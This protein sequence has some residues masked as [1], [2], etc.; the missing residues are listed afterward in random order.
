VA[1]F[2][3]L[4]LSKLSEVSVEEVRF[5]IEIEDLPNDIQLQQDSALSISAKVKSSGFGFLPLSFGGYDPIVLNAE[6]DLRRL[7]DNQYLWN[8]GSGFENLQLKVSET[9]EIITTKSDS[10][11]FPYEVLSSKKLPIKLNSDIDFALGFDMLKPL[12]LS[13]DSVLVIGPLKA[14]DSITA[15]ETELIKLEAVKTSIDEAV[16]LI[17]P[18]DRS[19]NLNLDKISVRGTVERFTE[20]SIVIPIE[21]INVPE[22]SQINFFPKDITLNYYVSLDNYNNISA[23]DFEVICDFQETK[24]SGESYLRP[25]INSKSDLVKSVRANLNKIDFIFL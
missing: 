4:M 9:L 1:A 14:I 15:I 2:V 18:L 13:Q 8:L 5:K 23:K 20:G 19:I 10:V 17:R 22:G 12:E 3:F 21:V 24:E 16:K 25:Q 6:Q 11:F 7:K